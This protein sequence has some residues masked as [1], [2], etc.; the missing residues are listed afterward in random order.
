MNLKRVSR[1]EDKKQQKVKKQKSSKK[2]VLKSGKTTST[3]KVNKQEEKQV[4]QT[5]AYNR[6]DTLGKTIIRRF[7][8]GNVL[9]IYTQ[10]NTQMQTAFTGI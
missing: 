8:V 5:A 3:C 1:E 6:V 9:K 10:S 2:L 7:T 4:R